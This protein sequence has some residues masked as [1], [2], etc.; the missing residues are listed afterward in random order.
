MWLVLALSIKARAYN[1]NLCGLAAASTQGVTKIE[2]T[3]TGSSMSIHSFRRP[4]TLV[5][6][7]APVEQWRSVWRSLAKNSRALTGQTM[8]RWHISMQCAL[9]ICRLWHPFLPAAAQSRDDSAR[10]SMSKVKGDLEE[11][12]AP[13]SQR[14][15]SLPFKPVAL[16]FQNIKYSVPLPAVRSGAVRVLQPCAPCLLNHLHLGFGSAAASPGVHTDRPTQEQGWRGAA[17]LV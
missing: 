11:G 15:S 13:S 9:E 5:Y 17:S 7:F 10:P 14:N 16:T 12:G 1:P 3:P 6:F 2:A 4:G 8:G